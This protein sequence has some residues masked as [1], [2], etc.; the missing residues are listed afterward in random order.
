LPAAFGSSERRRLNNPVSEML[1][2]LTQFRL[3]PGVKN[4]AFAAGTGVN[5]AFT[6]DPE[7]VKNEVTSNPS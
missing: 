3:I 5:E 7:I 2:D 6:K 1:Q 4:N